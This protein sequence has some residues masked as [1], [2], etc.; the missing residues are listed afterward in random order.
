MSQTTV[1]WDEEALDTL[2]KIPAMV[3]PMIKKKIEKTAVI[4]RVEIITVEFMNHVKERQM[5]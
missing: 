3:R 4:E 5:A 1:Q 2:N